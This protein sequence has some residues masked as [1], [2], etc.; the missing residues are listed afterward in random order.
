MNKKMNKTG[1][2]I[3]ILI[4]TVAGAIAANVLMSSS[5]I[6]EGAEKEL[7]SG[8][9]STESSDAVYSVLTLRTERSSIENY[10]KFNGDVIADTTVEI[11]PDTSG[12]LT[13]VYVSLGDYVR[14]NQVIAEVDPSLPGRNFVA[15]PVR[16]TING[17]ITDLPYRVGATISSP[18]VPLATVGDLSALQIQSY[19]SEKDMASVKLGQKGVITFEPY[20][21][22]TFSATVSEISPVLN[23]NSR[24][25][26]IKLSIDEL[27]SRIKSGMF[28]SVYLITEVLEDV[29]VIPSSSILKSDEGSYVYVVSSE[30]K[31]EKRMVETGIAID[32]KTVILS[33]L[34]ESEELVV[35]GQTML[36]P[37]AAVKINS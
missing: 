23:R 6:A 28:G 14:K 21:N 37:G 27:D 35:L 19:I 8:N 5:L 4:L 33:G 32:G 22:E 36:Q 24:T 11:Y 20:G 16:S 13:G 9:L 7:Q 12:K 30:R 1:V 2:I 15:S 17:T 34:N 25:L 3:V 26:E 18:Q 31:A 29:M 10:L